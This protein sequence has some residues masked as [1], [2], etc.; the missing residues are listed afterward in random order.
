MRY[1]GQAYELSMPVDDFVSGETPLPQLVPRF[2]AFHRSRYGHASSREGVE[3]VNFR[4]TAVHRS[5][6]QLAGM[7]PAARA[8]EL[9]TDVA[10][11][12][13]DGQEHACRFYRREG[14][15]LGHVIRGPAVIEEATA[16]AFVPG[17]W[18][19]SVEN[20]GN[21]LLRRT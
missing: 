15:P 4:V 20:G 1:V 6:V 14:L 11:I 2:H 5:A 17:G 7:S 16:T 13:L 8:A 21:M 10:P 18:V 3:I 12:W 9:A 19:A